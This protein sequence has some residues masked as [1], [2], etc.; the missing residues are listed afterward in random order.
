ML[1]IAIYVRV[2]TEE[3]VKNGV[4]LDAQSKECIKYAKSNGYDVVD[5]YRDE[6]FSAKTMDR[7]ELQKFLN[8]ATS[9]P[10][11]YDALLVWKM[12]RLS[13]SVRDHIHLEDLLKG[14]GVRVLSVTEQNDESDEGDLLRGISMHLAQYEIRK[15]ARRCLMG[16]RERLSQGIWTH[17][18]PIGYKATRNEKGEPHAVIGEDGDKVKRLF[19][20]FSTGAF[21]Q[22][23]LLALGQRIG[24]TT[25]NDA[26]LSAQ[27][28]NKLLRNPFYIGYIRSNLL[29]EVVKGQHDALVSAEVFEA[30]QA[31]LEGTKDVRK[32][33]RPRLDPD[34]PLRGSQ[35]VCSSCGHSLTGGSPRGRSAYYPKYN[36]QFC[37]KKDTGISMSIDR[38]KLHD[39]FKDLL[40]KIQ[41]EPQALEEFKAN[42]LTVWRDTLK[43]QQQTATK[44][45]NAL[46]ELEEKRLHILNQFVDNNLTNEQ[47][48]DMLAEVEPKISKIVLESS[49]A[50]N[51]AH[52]ELSMIQYAANFL[53]NLSK[54]WVD[55]DPE[56]K[57]LFIDTVFP[58]G[59]VFEF[60]KGFR[61]AQLSPIF[62]LINASREVK[63]DEKST[64]VIPT[65]VE[66]VL[67][68]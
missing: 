21:K 7:P 27:T 36:C 38:E 40:A 63:D 12:D 24:L 30:V 59:L 22:T 15:H 60:G 47:K 16:M 39:Q 1:K 23:D 31:I 62:R 57:K 68:G 49:S 48:D 14:F 35:V 37:R 45:E 20:E 66:L 41:L 34:W 42:V 65:R 50:S 26:P 4:S 29:E 55:L 6:G 28:L 61:T 17:V 43:E 2:S 19:E 18:P 58:E 54:I 51:I 44:N 13:R 8:E 3:Q 46:K 10:G 67:P 33:Q 25:R 56:S 53:S 64:M 5:V 52:T 32:G 11:K 9:T